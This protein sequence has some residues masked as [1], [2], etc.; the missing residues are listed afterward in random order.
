MRRAVLWIIFTVLF[1]GLVVALLFTLN[2]FA[3]QEVKVLI[4]GY[5]Q[6]T[7]SLKEAPDVEVR[8]RFNPFRGYSDEVDIL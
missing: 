4:S 1:I 5:L 8:G 6:S 7:L 3:K 2:S